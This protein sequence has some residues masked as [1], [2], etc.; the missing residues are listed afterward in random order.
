MGEDEGKELVQERLE[1]LK[2]ARESDQKRKGEGRE[3]VRPG[4]GERFLFSERGR[5]GGAS[6]GAR[7]PQGKEREEVRELELRKER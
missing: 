2:D 1:R 5:S 6:F 3:K 7:A 4:V